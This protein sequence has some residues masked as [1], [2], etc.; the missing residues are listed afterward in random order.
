MKL[1]VDIY[2]FSGDIFMLTAVVLGGTVPHVELIHQLKKRGYYTVLLDYLPNPPARAVAD[3]HVQESTMDKDAVCRVAR[4]KRADLVITT[5]IDQANI[6]A[7]YAME[8]LGKCPPYSYETALRITNKG[9]MKRTMWENDIPTSRYL[10][11]EKD[12]D[13]PKKL[14]LHYP[15][16]VKP[17]DSNSSAGVKTAYNAIEAERYFRQAQQISRNGR[18]VCEE[19]VEGTEV[20]VYCF[21]SGGKARVLLIAE[22]LSLV[23]DGC[24]KCYGT[25]SG[26]KLPERITCRIQEVATAIAKA[27]ALDN[28]PMFMQIFVQEDDISVIEFAPRTGGGACYKTVEMSTG[29]NYIGACIDSFLGIPVMVPDELT[30]NYVVGDTILYGYP[31]V[32]REICGTQE[33]IARNEHVADLREVRSN[34]EII[35]KGTGNRERLAHVFLKGD[36]REEL[37]HAAKSSV[38]ELDA[39]DSEGNSMLRRDI[40]L[41]MER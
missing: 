16:M 26:M 7:C 29:F 12:Q 38:E 23:E 27:Y 9:D 11:F 15:I 39:L 2:I 40:W 32:F 17:A 37:F 1:I 8:Q 6:S 34:G 22:R 30:Q 24:F 18:V 35:S 21:V 4:Q 10:Y 36:T 3:E 41:G 5:S 13:F 14:S 20:S 25:I 31:G 33:L 28:T 19:V